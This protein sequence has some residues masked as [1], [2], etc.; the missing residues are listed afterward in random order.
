MSMPAFPLADAD[1]CVKCALCLPHCPTYRVSKDEGESPRGRIALMQGMATGKLEITPALTAHLDQ[2]LSCRACEAVCPAEVPYGKL[3]DAARRELRAHGHPEPLKARLFAFFMRGSWRLH[4]LQGLLRF[5]DKSGIN[6]FLL[7][8]GPASLKRLLRFMPT[9]PKPRRWDAVYEPRKASGEKVQLFLGCVA[10]ISQ[11]QVTASAIAV[12][13]AIGVEVQ[14]PKSQGC[15]GA[16]DQHAGRSGKAAEL[17]RNNLKAFTG[18]API[19]GSASGCTASLLEYD[20]IAGAGA[21]AQ[22]FALRAQDIAA[23]LARHPLISRIEFKDWEALALVQAPCTQR[24]VLK[25]EKA[26]FELL[27]LIPGLKVKAIPASMGCCGAAGSYMLTE[28][29]K[30]DAFADAYATYIQENKTEL[31]VTSNVG[32]SLHLR[33]ALLRKG[34]RIPVLH[35]IE[36]LALQLPDSM[37]KPGLDITKRFK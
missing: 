32:C 35:P 14:I 9:V 34:I 29:E 15:C 11:P 8:S 31:L 7:K 19:L 25:S 6:G 26:G 24:N 4:L 33:A 22:A 36:V 37:Y 30:A 21:E 10:D 5:A 28:P 23:W 13:N 18:D 16:L 20:Q 2:C 27:K 1:K 3:I 17:A 12:L